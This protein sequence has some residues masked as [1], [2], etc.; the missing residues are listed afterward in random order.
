MNTSLFSHY[1]KVAVRSLTRYK[2]QTIISIVGLAVGFVCLSLSALWLRYENTFNTDLP[3]ADRLYMMAM[4]DKGSVMG[5]PGEF[6]MKYAEMPEGQS[7]AERPTK[8]AAVSVW[9]HVP[10][11]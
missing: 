4:G 1:L 6:L 9:R 2:S 3:D 5:T 10:A 7:R 8:A 11:L